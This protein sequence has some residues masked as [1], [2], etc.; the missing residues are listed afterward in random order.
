[1]AERE[2]TPSNRGLA[3]LGSTC[4]MNAALQCLIHT[5]ELSHIFLNRLYLTDLNVDNLQLAKVNPKLP[6]Q[7]RLAELFAP[8]V[9]EMHSQIGNPFTPSD[10][11]TI[12]GKVDATFVDV[13]THEDSQECMLKIL[14]G[15]HEAC[16]RMR[17][18]VP[19]AKTELLCD[20]SD[21]FENA[22]ESLTRHQMWFGHSLVTDIFDGQYRTQMT[23]KECKRVSV[24]FDTV[25]FLA[26]E[27]KKVAPNASH[28]LCVCNF[29][30]GSTRATLS[31]KSWSL[32]SLFSFRAPRRKTPLPPICKRCLMPTCKRSSSPAPIS[33]G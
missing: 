28:A 7:C 29:V 30:C 23:C 26:L 3:N 17:E 19:M 33:T 14:D 15:I 2:W 8:L 18:K 13:S 1:M 10:F 6:D 21:D 16:N 12:L 24:K 27:F 5:T 9:A 20:G 31:S 32:F 25:R 22:A 11:H 4:Y